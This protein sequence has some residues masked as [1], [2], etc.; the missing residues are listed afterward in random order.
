MP[1]PSIYLIS[2]DISDKK[3]LRLLHKCVSRQA[4]RLQLSVYYL[5]CNKDQLKELLSDIEKIIKP[6]EDDVRIYPALAIN[7]FEWI[8]QAIKDDGLFMIN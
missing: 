8:G 6:S 1:S 3:R 7:N 5:E 4:L 2:Y